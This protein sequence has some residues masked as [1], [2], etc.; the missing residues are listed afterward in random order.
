MRI[1]FARPPSPGA[2][3]MS[4]F[5][6]KHVVYVAYCRTLTCPGF[7][8]TD[9]NPVVLEPMVRAHNE[10]WHPQEQSDE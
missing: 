6:E 5:I 8:R 9:S 10:R 3:R 1:D 7:Y 4:A 2:E